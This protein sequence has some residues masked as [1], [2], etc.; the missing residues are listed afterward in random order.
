MSLSSALSIAL[1]GLRVANTSID[2]AARNIANA[3]TPGYTR[4]VQLPVAQLSG[5]IAT[6]VELG[7]VKRDI[8]AFLQ[9]QLRT[10]VAIGA[11]V[12]TRA[13]FLARIDAMFGR[14]GEANALDTILSGFN[15]ALQELS[16]TPDA[17]SARDGAVNH[18][19]NLANQ[20]NRLSGD[21][22]L[23]RQETEL[24]LNDAVA[25]ANLAL[26][27]IA[28]LNTEISA[29]YDDQLG[30]ADVADRRDQAIDRLAQLLDIR[31]LEGER[32]TVRVFTNGGNLLVDGQAVTLNFDERSNIGPA[33]RYSE[34]ESERSVG[35]L[36]IEGFGGASLDLFR[37]GDIGS[38][39]IAALKE[40]R[41]ETLVQAQAQLDEL[42]H[43][44][45]LAMSSAQVA[46]TA[47]SVGPQTGFDLDVADLAAGNPIQVT[48]TQGGTPQTF[49]FIRV[50]DPATLPLPADA[51]AD[52]ND[53]VIGIDFSGGLAGAAAAMDA[54]LDAALG[55]DV[56]VSSP[57]ANT[58]Q[59][60]NDAGG[61]VT[62]DTVQ[63]TVTPMATQDS[64]LQLALF[65]DGGSPYTGSFDGVS[66][67]IGL[68]GRI[69]VNAAVVNDSSLLVSYSTTPPTGSG[70]PARPLELL[71]RFNETAFTFSPST[72]LGTPGS[73][74][75]TSIREFGQRVINF[76]GQQA[77]N[78]ESVQTAQ[79]IV[80]DSLNDRFKADT[81]V[82]IDEELA[83]LTEL[84]NAYAANA[85][86]MSVVQELIDVLLRV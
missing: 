57:G 86:V 77:Q 14:P 21:I 84:Q 69:A 39:R 61:T 73:P 80:V 53:T 67:R 9:Q 36:T 51:T 52:P 60:L 23:M 27:E 43:G 13:Q 24:G 76:Q 12:D 56:A 62:I 72:G 2:L 41:D 85:R 8:D 32:G 63:A 30:F 54:A 48:I 64:G 29:R 6:G 17:F 47:A 75:S 45:A 55:V 68:A 1:S 10:E 78:A 16:T 34:T 25:E 59:I 31:V 26:Q 4:K 66:Q 20:L 50:D 18:A 15:N 49:T 71:A 37:H 5:G 7:D 65:T 44:L 79:G 46:G 38:G 22:Q 81:E 82:N 70:D 58:L 35:T 74:L 33:S 42:A 83:R 28:Q 40:L 11:A 3:N 19:A